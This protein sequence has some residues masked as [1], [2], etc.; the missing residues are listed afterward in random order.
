ME[1]GKFGH[2]NSKSKQSPVHYRIVYNLEL[3][4]FDFVIGTGNGKAEF[5]LDELALRNLLNNLKTGE[6]FA[7]GTP[8]TISMNVLITIS[9]T[10]GAYDIVI[11]KLNPAKKIRMTGI[12]GNMYQQLV[13]YTEMVLTSYEAAKAAGKI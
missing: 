3:K 2:G 8:L 11:E 9:K 4:R 6:L 10:T 7:N 12:S 5:T 13:E 1:I